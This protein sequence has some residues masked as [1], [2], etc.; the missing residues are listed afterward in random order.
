MEGLILYLHVGTNPCVYPFWSRLFLGGRIGHPL[1]V[2]PNEET[3]PQ[4]IYFCVHSQLNSW[5]VL[6]PSHHKAVC[7]KFHT[8]IQGCIYKP[9]G[10][11]AMER[12]FFRA[13]L[14]L[15]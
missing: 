14:P 2:L 8:L 15:W 5:Q 1:L 11:K 6:F 7:Y 9:Q 10:L 12:L 3:L 13:S 4:R